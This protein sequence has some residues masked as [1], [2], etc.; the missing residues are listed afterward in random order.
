MTGINKQ[1]EKKVIRYSLS[2][3]NQVFLQVPII[4]AKNVN[5]VVMK[6]LRE[7]SELQAKGYAHMHVHNF[8]LRERALLTRPA[9]NG[10][11]NCSEVLAS[12][13]LGTNQILVV[14]LF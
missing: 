14:K 11:S 12:F 5:G 6:K 2:R 9:L 3:I 13:L 1:K 8:Y 4:T 10:N 7:V